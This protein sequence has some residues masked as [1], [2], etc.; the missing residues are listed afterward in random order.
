[1]DVSRELINKTIADIFKD[2]L[3]IQEKVLRENGINLSI[4]EIHT[5]EAIESLKEY[6]M[7]SEV[8][9]VLNITA[10]T[11][12][13]N[14]NRL[15]K[16]GYVHKKQDKI[17]R[18]ITH[19]ALSDEAINVLNVHKKFHQELIDSFFKDLKIDEDKVLLESLEKI[20]HHLEHLKT[21]TYHYE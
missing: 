8:A 15:V 12:S 1:M 7:M 14:I 17:D 10:S 19:L 20:V 3:E 6:S 18:R 21:K 4:T 13:I 9:R 5:L 16:K 2:V 11:L